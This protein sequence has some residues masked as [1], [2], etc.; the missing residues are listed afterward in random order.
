M[1]GLDDGVRWAF[2][3]TGSAIRAE[4]GIDDIDVAFANG[5]IWANFS[6]HATGGAFIGDFVSH[7]FFLSR[8]GCCG[9][10]DGDL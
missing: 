1:L 4:R 9:H 3:D 7:G 2:I 8:K 6:T 10:D 5:L